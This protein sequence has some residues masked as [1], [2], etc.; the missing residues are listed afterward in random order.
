[1]D[2]LAHSLK[3][4]P[5]TSA[6]VHRDATLDDLAHGNQRVVGHFGS[7]NLEH[8]YPRHMDPDWAVVFDNECPGD[9]ERGRALLEQAGIP[10]ERES[11]GTRLSARPLAPPPGAQHRGRRAP[12]CP[13]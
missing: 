8:Y 2:A 10:G 6:E 7:S 5:F 3:H 11:P 4:G 1:M 9:P 12:L 13:R